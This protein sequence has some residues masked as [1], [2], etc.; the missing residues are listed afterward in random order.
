MAITI[1][2][3]TVNFAHLDRDSLLED[4]HWL[5][6]PARLPILLTAIGDAFVQDTADRAV[7]LLDTAA[8]ELVPV[9][10]DD[11]AF[12]ALLEDREFVMGHYAVYAVVDLRA[13]GLEL[14]EGR[15]AREKV[16][17]VLAASTRS[18]T[19]GDRHRRAFSLTARSREARDAVSD[20]PTAAGTGSA[21][22][23]GWDGSSRTTG[24]V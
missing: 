23:A 16:P 4:W 1:D 13:N 6:G 17:P 21:D 3:L 7:S 9:A 10:A 11:E 2:D 18:P 15:S 8:G 5:I 19:R 12:R 22:A 24:I 14:G 20:Q